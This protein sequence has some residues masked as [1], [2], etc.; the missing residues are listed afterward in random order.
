MKR[1]YHILTIVV[2]GIIITDQFTKY[3]IHQTF[4]LHQSYVII[5][6]FFNLT[7]IQNP[8]AAFGIF[9]DAGIVFRTVFLTGVGFLAI[10]FLGYYFQKSPESAWKTHLSFALILGGAFGNLIDRIRLGTVVDFLDFYLG[11]FHWPAFNV[12]DSAISV[13]LTLL[14][15]LFLTNSKGEEG[16][17]FLS[18]GNK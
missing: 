9:A 16:H 3:L 11:R 15:I 5:N 7:Y 2:G 6:G 12:A 14:I 8:G 1:K 10:F 17:V 4:D 13:G 18:E